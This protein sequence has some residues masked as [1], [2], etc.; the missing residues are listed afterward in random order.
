MIWQHDDLAAVQCPGA[1]PSTGYT[2]LKD[3]SMSVL[4]GN[5][6]IASFFN[7]L[8]LLLEQDAFD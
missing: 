2:A 5:V 6:F 7:G 8:T 4:K 3:R 1:M